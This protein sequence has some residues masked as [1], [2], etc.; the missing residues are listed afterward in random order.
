MI[1]QSFGDRVREL[2]T[3]QG[4]SQ[5]KFALIAGLDRT[6]LASLEKGKRNVSILNLQK[7]ANALGMTIS[8]LFEGVVDDAR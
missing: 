1:L 7:I 6:Y 2:R 3:Q 5:E 4:L 8:E